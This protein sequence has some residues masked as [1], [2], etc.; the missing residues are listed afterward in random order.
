LVKAILD[1]EKAWQSSP[2]SLE[3]G[4]HIAIEN[5]LSATTLLLSIT[6]FCVYYVLYSI[7]EITLINV[8]CC[9]KRSRYNRHK[10]L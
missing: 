10:Y 7:E 3:A 6:S 1:A 5:L 4:M 2:L 9:V 8:F